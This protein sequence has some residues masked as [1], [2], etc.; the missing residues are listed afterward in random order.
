MDG[1]TIRASIA[2]QNVDFVIQ[3]PHQLHPL[4][5]LTFGCLLMSY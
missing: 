1:G 2:K 3:T 5:E 4:K